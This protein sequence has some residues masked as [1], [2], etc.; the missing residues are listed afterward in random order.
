MQC[1][2]CYDLVPKASESVSAPA[3][4]AVLIH[5]I[6]PPFCAQLA[7]MSSALS[8]FSST[9]DRS[10]HAGIRLKVAQVEASESIYDKRATKNQLELDLS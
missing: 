2:C 1:R 6:S 9:L 5:W 3:A 7:E 8:D 4:L 10:G